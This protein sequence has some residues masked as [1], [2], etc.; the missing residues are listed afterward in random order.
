MPKVSVIIPI[1][2]VEKYI[3]RCA[4]SLFEQTLDDM[5]FIFV[6]DCTTDNSISVLKSVV[7]KYPNRTSQVRLLHHNVNKGLSHARETGI[8]SATGE[9]IA[10][11]DS[12]D[13]VDRDMY[14]RMYDF[15]IS[16][17]YDLVKC[18]H[19]KTDGKTREVVPVC[20]TSASP[21]KT[22]VI[23]NLLLERNWNNIWNI[24]V[25]SYIYKSSEIEF[26]DD[27][28]LEDFFVVTQLLLRCNRIG[29]V[30]QPFYNYFKN[31]Q[32][33]CGVKT[34]SAIIKKRNKVKKM[35]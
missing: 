27:T 28:M 20:C 5:E 4:R 16:G 11:C 7:E 31:P 2:G 13:W 33:I 34:E 3:E 35:L 8:N 9:Y 17:N 23:R 30:D 21:S 6:D 19:C 24:L 14:K 29:V 15:A 10:H 22:E 32:S 12:D 1:Y 25:K 26:T 18:G